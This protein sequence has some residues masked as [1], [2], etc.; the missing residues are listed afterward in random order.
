MNQDSKQALLHHRQIIREK[1]FLNNI[2]R[3][4]Y[5]DFSNI[6]FPAGK[7]VEIG[8]G[9][10]FIKEIIPE[11][12]TSDVIAGPDIDKVFFAHKMPFKDSSVSGFLMIDVLHHIKDSEKS[13]K[14]MGRC[15]KKGGKIVMV[16]PFIT[17][18]GYFIYKFLHPERFDPKA[19]WKIQGKG[20]MSDSNTALPWIIF[21]RDR[22]IFEQKFP[23]L[24]ILRIEPHSPIRYLVSGGVTKPQ[25]IP[26]FLYQTIKD[27]EGILS[28]FNSY[29]GMFV[30]IELEKVV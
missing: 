28:P 27:L 5:I 3:D 19:G 14:E 17:W 16:E 13:F 20:R 23:E 21:K 18:W 26:T 10:G 15:L 25:L 8:S 9:A 29:I 24:R 7:I 22:K 1:K 12:L 30:T 4:L 6:K 11:V 2:Y